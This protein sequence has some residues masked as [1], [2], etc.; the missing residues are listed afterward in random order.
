MAD[1]I[2]RSIT[3]F[4]FTTLRVV[5]NLGLKQLLEG[6]TQV[7]QSEEAPVDLLYFEDIGR[8]LPEITFSD[9]NL[10]NNSLIVIANTHKTRNN[11]KAWEALIAD[12]KITVSIDLFW[13]GLL[14]V[15]KEQVKQH[16][17]IR[18]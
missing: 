17:S 1:L 12:P 13:C 18:L 9:F 11:L 14:F 8:V 15:R 5:G 2:L 3:Y 10:H 7:V 4:H 16:F 6:E